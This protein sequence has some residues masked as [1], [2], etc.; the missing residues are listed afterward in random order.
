[1]KNKTPLVAEF[2]RVVKEVHGDG[3]RRIKQ[4][5]RNQSH[6]ESCL[7]SQNNTFNKILNETKNTQ[8]KVKKNINGSHLEAT[9]V[10]Q[11]INV[12]YI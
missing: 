6:M 7:L 11:E 3:F 10:K 4:H 12:K 8:K 2:E 5:I 9:M 1:L